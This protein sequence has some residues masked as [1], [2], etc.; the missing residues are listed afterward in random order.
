MSPRPYGRA[1]AL[2]ASGLLV[3]LIL[4]EIGVRLLQPIPSD[5]LLPLAYNREP[6]ERLIAGGTYVRFDHDLGWVTADSAQGQDGSAVYR[7]NAD[8]QRADRDYVLSPP[9][10]V[11]RL[12]AFGDSFTHC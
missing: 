5:Q 12:A 6:L 8:G 1:L 10:G 11:R 2:I 4:A 3:A 7:T 9:A